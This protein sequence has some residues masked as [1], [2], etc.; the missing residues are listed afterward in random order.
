MRLHYVSLL[1]AGAFFRSAKANSALIG[2]T[3]TT[4]SSVDS[5]TAEKDDVFV[6]RFLRT[7]IAVDEDDKDGEQSTIAQKTDEERAFSFDFRASID[8]LKS[9]VQ[10]LLLRIFDSKAVEKAFEKHGLMEAGESL[11]ELEEFNKW[12]EETKKLRPLN[13]NDE[14][15]STLLRYYKDDVLYK[16]LDAKN[17]EEVVTDLQNALIKSWLTKN[18]SPIDVFKIV[19]QDSKLDDI[20]TSPSLPVWT[21]YLDDYNKGNIGHK[22][23]EFEVLVRCYGETA[24]SEMLKAMKKVGSTNELVAKL[25]KQQTK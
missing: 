25:Q 22:M 14:A 18:K 23:N 20:L 8:A 11:L 2:S 1:V 19:E 17:T 3:P 12:L 6:L 5:L 4:A 13:F 7:T 16:I 15:V 10:T 24:V 9:K 21:K